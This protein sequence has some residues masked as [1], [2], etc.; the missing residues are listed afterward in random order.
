MTCPEK[1]ADAT[2]KKNTIANNI[3]DHRICL[4]IALVD[5]GRFHVQPTE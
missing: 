5:I 4:V 3:G 1:I 2:D